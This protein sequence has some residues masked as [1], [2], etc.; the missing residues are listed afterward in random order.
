MGRFVWDHTVKVTGNT[1]ETYICAVF[2]VCNTL[3]GNLFSG[4]Q[5]TTSLLL[6]FLN[7]IS[8]YFNLV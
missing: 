5:I 8:N 3:L 2:E 7:V 4:I 6:V 1:H